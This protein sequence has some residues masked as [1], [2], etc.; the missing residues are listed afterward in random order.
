[1]L[2]G[3]R[4]VNK[5]L[6]LVFPATGHTVGAPFDLHNSVEKKCKLNHRASGEKARRSLSRRDVKHRKKHF[7]SKTIQRP[8]I[9]A[10]VQ[11]EKNTSGRCSLGNKTHRRESILL[12]IHQ[13]RVRRKKTGGGG[14]RGDGVQGVVVLRVHPSCT[15]VTGFGEILLAMSRLEVFFHFVRNILQNEVL[16]PS[17]YGSIERELT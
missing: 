9:E 11:Q 13:T 5:F 3:S 14:K 15:V 12:T 7:F 16:P 8:S 2:R 17:F 1:M 4:L 10:P 6:Y